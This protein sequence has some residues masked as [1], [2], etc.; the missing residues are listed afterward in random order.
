V[1]LL[2]ALMHKGKAEE[3]WVFTICWVFGI[4]YM[5][6]LEDESATLVRV[7]KEPPLLS[8][9]TSQCGKSKLLSLSME[10]YKATELFTNKYGISNLLF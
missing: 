4:D 2:D 5:S 7:F 10:I 3:K 1:T 8:V 6:F 9:S